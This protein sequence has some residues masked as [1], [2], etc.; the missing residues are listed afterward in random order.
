MTLAHVGI[1]AIL[2]S[3][4]VPRW[5]DFLVPVDRRAEG[6]TA[7]VP[8]LESTGEN[9]QRDDQLERARRFSDKVVEEEKKAD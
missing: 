9:A 3:F 7:T 6:D 5:F 1:A 2:F 4:L 8:L